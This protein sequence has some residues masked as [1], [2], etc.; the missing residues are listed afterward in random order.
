MHV[1]EAQ[2]IPS[3][4]TDCAKDDAGS[5]CNEDEVDDEVSEGEVGG[6]EVLISVLAEPAS[7]NA[8]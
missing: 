3:H 2:L 8:V 6:L 7:R 4:Q 5:T 1:E